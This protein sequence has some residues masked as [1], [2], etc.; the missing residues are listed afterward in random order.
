MNLIYNLT[1][2]IQIINII[3]YNYINCFIKYVINFSF[4]LLYLHHLQF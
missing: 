1:V 2:Y 4:Q 3:I